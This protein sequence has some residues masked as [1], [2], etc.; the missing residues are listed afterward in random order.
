MLFHCTNIEWDTDG[1]VVDLPK[2]IDVE[3]TPQ[4]SDVPSELMEWEVL[5]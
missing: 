1:E 2:E 5:P 3:M 4:P